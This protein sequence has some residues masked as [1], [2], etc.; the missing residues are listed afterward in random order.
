MF[1]TFRQPLERTGYLKSVHVALWIGL[2][3]TA[4]MLGNLSLAG[5]L[6]AK[7]FG[8]LALFQ[9]ILG[10]SVG[11]APLGLDSLV[12]RRE[13]LFS[14]GN[15]WRASLAGA[16]TAL[17]AAAVAAS[18]FELTPWA[19]GLVA[20]AVLAA[21]GARM[22]AAAEQARVR[23]GRSQLLA[24]IPSLSFGVGGILLASLGVEDWH[25]GATALA[26]GYLFA[27]IV[28]LALARFAAFKREVA[29]AP[30]FPDRHAYSKAMAFVGIL[31]SVLLLQQIER[32]VIPARLG[33]EDLAT[34]ALVATIVGSPYRVLQGGIGYALMPRL[35]AEVTRAGRSRLVRWEMRLA[36]IL[37]VGGGLVL[38]ILARPVI[39]AFYG[40][41][42]SVSLALVVAIALVGVVR[43]FYAVAAATVSAIGD[44]RGLRRF[45]GLGWLAVALAAGGAL[46]LS[47]YGLVGVVAGAALGWLVRLAAAVALAR[48]SLMSGGEGDSGLMAAPT[49]AD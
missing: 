18:A 1:P 7:D 32:L 40:D 2:G 17:V 37:G 30:A 6:P 21:S 28:G 9:A 48:S 19:I 4:Y 38:T 39:R 11:L 29:R 13:L 35:R 33:L 15:L 31:A 27:A 22:C 10:V 25:W 5:V 20:A 14:P 3:G 16:L 26:V 23:L 8:R 43:V 45:N 34:F 46:L 24:Q 49:P 47:G 36:T 44:R 12:V 42:Y 41:K